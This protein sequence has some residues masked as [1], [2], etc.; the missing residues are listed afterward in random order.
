MIKEI[1]KDIN[2]KKDVTL[3]L[4]VTDEEGNILHTQVCNT[5]TFGF[6]SVIYSY[7]TGMAL[8]FRDLNEL[9]TGS[10]DFTPIWKYIPGFLTNDTAGIDDSIRDIDLITLEGTPLHY[11]VYSTGHGLNTGDTIYIMGANIGGSP[12]TPDYN[13]LCNGIVSVVKIDN[14]SFTPQKNGGVIEPLDPGDEHDEALNLARIR[15][16]FTYVGSG[17]SPTSDGQNRR[18]DS[19]SFRNVDIRCG[20]LD[21]PTSI[22][23]SVLAC[24][25]PNGSNDGQLSYDSKTINTPSVGVT[26]SE[27][28]I[29]R[30]IVNNSANNITIKEIGM[31][32]VGLNQGNNYDFWTLL[33]RDVLNTPITILSGQTLLFT[34]RISTDVTSTSG[35]LIQ[36]NELLYRQIAQ[37]SR[38]AKD[39]FNNN[40]VRSISASQ[41][42]CMGTGGESRVYQSTS[43]GQGLTHKYLGPQVGRPDLLG[44]LTKQVVNTNY[45]LQYLEDASDARIPHSD[46]GTVN[47]LVYHGILGSVLYVDGVANSVYFTIERFFENNSGGD[48]IVDEIGLYVGFSTG[49]GR[50]EDS[51]CIART[52]V[53]PSITLSDGEF[54]LVRYKIQISGI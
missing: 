27:L 20:S 23:D 38:E 24:E 26:I 1:E 5:L 17:S 40:I 34:Y 19:R 47:T 39:V 53:S 2:F 3:H 32:A 9:D 11:V 46:N 41:F 29:Q 43:G 14:D 48:I 6:L 31:Y 36:F 45:R 35:I 44:T 13:N 12:G 8:Q 25:I 10:P 4:D 52:L 7:M 51:H 15:R 21:D 37:T 16:Q 18:A 30:D 28:A 42:M 49:I 54:L 50:I 22:V 33:A